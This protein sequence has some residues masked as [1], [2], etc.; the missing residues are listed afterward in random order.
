[1][2]RGCLD[3]NKAHSVPAQNALYPASRVD[4]SDTDVLKIQYYTSADAVKHLIP[5]DFELADEP[6]VTACLF[7][8][9]YSPFGAYSEM[10]S[11][12]EVTWAG[13]KY[14]FA[15]EL[16]LENEGALFMG[17]EQLGVP[18]V[19]G[20]VVFDPSNTPQT[21]GYQLG[22]VERPVGHKII[23]FG[24]KPECKVHG[25]KSLSL[26]HPQKAILALRI[27]PHLHN[28]HPPVVR[29]YVAIRTI[30][31]EGELWTGTGSVGF[32]PLSG[33]SLLAQA[34]VRRYGESILLRKSSHYISP[35]LKGFALGDRVK[36]KG[37]G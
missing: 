34:P 6:L 22:H 29:E 2:P 36:E 37:Q 13:V 30:C 31:T 12:I 3:A 16:I 7:Y 27:L 9:G 17:R 32:V 14:D 4:F 1:M 33:F 8:W 28:D 23:E 35:D 26:P 10:V 11:T 15:L 5:D 19:I 20:R 25:L 21:P 24:F 18:K